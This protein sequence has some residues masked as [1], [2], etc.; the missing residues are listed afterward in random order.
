MWPTDTSLTTKLY[1]CR[2]ELEKTITLIARTELIV[3]QRTPKKQQY[4]DENPNGKAEAVAY[5]HVR[6]PQRLARAR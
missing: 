6:R 5:V 2:Q 3:W 4:A 1:G